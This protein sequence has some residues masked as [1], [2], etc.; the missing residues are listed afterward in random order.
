[1]PQSLQDVINHK[2][3]EISTCQLPKQQGS[4][5][6]LTQN[7]QFSVSLNPRG[8]FQQVWGREGWYHDR[9]KQPSY[10]LLFNP[11]LN[12]SKSKEC[13]FYCNM[14]L[15]VST[16]KSK[17]GKHMR[18]KVLLQWGCFCWNLKCLV[19]THSGCQRILQK[20]TD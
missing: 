19:E 1:M 7:Q 13:F 2:Q 16:Q 15:H 6:V 12:V 20:Y 9:Y 17:H 5:S 11:V 10:N 14:C 4:I 18:L 3:N 8:S